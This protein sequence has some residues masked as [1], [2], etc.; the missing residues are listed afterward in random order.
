MKQSSAEFTID[1]VRYLLAS[2]CERAI[3]P[4]L[5]DRVIKHLER[6]G[7]DAAFSQFGEASCVGT[8]KICNRIETF[9][10]TINPQGNPFNE[11]K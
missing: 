6:I 5:C 2:G 8:T 7:K 4:K 10:L 3:W 11:V 9:K 1:N